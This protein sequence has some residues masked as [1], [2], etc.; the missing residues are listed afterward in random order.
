MILEGAFLFLIFYLAK[1]IKLPSKHD[2]QLV[3]VIYFYIFF[4]TTFGIFITIIYWFIII[5]PRRVLKG[6]EGKAFILLIFHLTYTMY[7]DPFVFRK[8]CFQD[9]CRYQNL[10]MLQSLIK[11][12]KMCI[13]IMHTLLYTCLDFYNT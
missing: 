7:N 4:A 1:C 8:D 11:G 3:Q 12:F 13:S 9:P 5:F 6:L 10:H 2:I